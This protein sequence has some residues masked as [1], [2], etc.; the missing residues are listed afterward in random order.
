LGFVDECYRKISWFQHNDIAL[1]KLDNPV[2]YN[3]KIQPICLPSKNTDIGGIEGKTVTVMG[4]GRDRSWGQASEVLRYTEMP[5]W[6][7]SECKRVFNRFAPNRLQDSNICAGDGRRNKDA[8]IVS[9][10]PFKIPEI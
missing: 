4:W 10:A 9:K 1:L 2:E 8:C 6:K 7:L 5:M 3:Q